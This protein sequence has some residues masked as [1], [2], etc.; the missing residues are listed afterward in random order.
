MGVSWYGKEVV[1]YNTLTSYSLFAMGTNTVGQLAQN[2][3]T[4][5]SSPVQVP[6]T[7]VN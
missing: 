7:G 3:L 2:N 6:V 4:K 1:N 5:Y